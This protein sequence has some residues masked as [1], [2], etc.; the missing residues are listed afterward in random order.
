MC[1][2]ILLT[3]G[4]YGKLKNH[5]TSLGGR[6]DYQLDADQSLLYFFFATADQINLCNRFLDV[7][8]FDGTYKTNN[9]NMF[10]YHVVALDMNFM[11]I[12]VYIAF[13]SRETSTLL[14][15]FLSFFRQMSNNREFIGIVTDDSPAIGLF[16]DTSFNLYY[17]YACQKG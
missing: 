9:E 13:I 11:A 1:T 15:S 4:D 14:S 2:F 6:C 16:I 5:I 10:P 8:G 12:P 7:V 17:T 3:V